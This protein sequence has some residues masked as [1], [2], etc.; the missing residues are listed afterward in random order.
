MGMNYLPQPSDTDPGVFVFGAGIFGGCYGDMLDNAPTDWSE[1]FADEQDY[2]KKLDSY[3]S[4]EQGL[5]VIVMFH[6][7][8]LISR[9]AYINVGDGP[10]V[11]PNTNINNLGRFRFTFY[12]MDEGVEPSGGA[13]VTT[14]TISGPLST[15]FNDNGWDEAKFTQLI[16]D[17]RTRRASARVSI[18]MG[19]DFFDAQLM[20]L[21]SKSYS[22]LA[23]AFFMPQPDDPCLRILWTW[24]GEE[25]GID[26]GMLLFSPSTKTWI[27]VGDNA[28]SQVT[29]QSSYDLIITRI[30]EE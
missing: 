18:T 5:S 8:E 4:V 15:I 28:L 19:D 11:V 9:F 10:T 24:E 22:A 17:I 27:G 21:G 12:Y 6:E 2:I 30:E 16:E 23:T 29:G 1:T 26:A 3:F 13:K 25:M 7:E 20:V 14:E